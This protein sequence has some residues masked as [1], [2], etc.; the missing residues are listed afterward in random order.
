MPF[1]AEEAELLAATQSLCRWSAADGSDTASSEQ[2]V[3]ALPSTIDSLRLI[4]LFLRRDHPT[5]QPHHRSI[6][7]WQTAQTAL[8]PL[9]TTYKR[10]RQVVYPVM[11]LL[12][13]L[14][15][16][17]PGDSEA[18]CRRERLAHQKQIRTALLEGVYMDVLM[19]WLTPLLARPPATRSADD[20]NLIEL[21]LTLVKNLL[22]I[23]AGS[24]TQVNAAAEDAASSK[25]MEALQCMRGRPV[26]ERLIR[27]Y[28]ECG[29]LDML[30]ALCWQPEDLNK[31]GLLLLETVAHLVGGVSVSELL[32][33]QRKA[34]GEEEAKRQKQSAAASAQ[35]ARN[36]PAGQFSYLWRGQSQ[37]SNRSVSTS[38]PLPPPSA[39][40]TSSLGA[41]LHTARLNEKSRYV[42]PSRHSRF[43]TLLTLPSPLSASPDVSDISAPPVSSGTQ[44]VRNMFDMHAMGS[45]RL[46]SFRGR[47]P[48]Q[49][50]TAAA[51]ALST[52][53]E[54]PV[55]GELVEFVLQFISDGCYG[56]LMDSTIG[57]LKANVR[58]LRDDEKNW[59]AVAALMM[60]VWR[61]QQMHSIGRHEQL[62]SSN[63]QTE[64]QPSGDSSSSPTTT[65][66]T[67]FFNCE[68]VMSCLSAAA[69]SLLTSKLLLYIQ[70][71]PSP[72]SCLTAS[73]QLYSELVHTLSCMLRTASPADREA[74]N[75][76][77]HD[78]YY[79]K[80][81]LD[82]LVGL[83]R[84]W[85][86]HSWGGPLMALLVECVH[87]SMH[88]LD[89]VDGVHTISQRRKK[90]V[91]KNRTVLLDGAKQK[92]PIAELQQALPA[93][94]LLDTRSTS[95]PQQPEEQPGE[96]QH[97]QVEPAMAVVLPVSEHATVKAAVLQTREILFESEAQ[98]QA[99]VGS[100]V[101]SAEGVPEQDALVDHPAQD[102]TPQT[103]D[104]IAERSDA[105]HVATADSV[106]TQ[107]A[108]LPLPA[109]S[110]D[111]AADTVHL[112]DVDANEYVPVASDSVDTSAA[113]LELSAD[114]QEERTRLPVDTQ[115]QTLLL[116][117][118][119]AELDV[120]PP[121]HA[122]TTQPPPA[123]AM[124]DTDCANQPGVGAASATP[125]EQQTPT[126]HSF[127]PPSSVSDASLSTLISDMAIE[128]LDVVM[129]SIAPDD[130]GATEEQ[131]KA[132]TQPHI[133]QLE[134]TTSASSN[135]QASEE[136][137]TQ[138]RASLD[139]S[140]LTP[141]LAIEVPRDSDSAQ[142]SE[143]GYHRAAADV[144]A[145]GRVAIVAAVAVQH[146]ATMSPVTA[147]IASTPT[148]DQ[149]Q[150]AVSATPGDSAAV[151]EALEAAAAEEVE[152]SED[153]YFRMEATFNFSAYLLSYATPTI[154]SHYL[155]LLA[156][157]RTNS[158]SLNSHILHFLSRLAFDRQLLPMLFQLS[159][160][161]V[162]DA[163]LNDPLLKAEKSSPRWKELTS[164]CK[165][166]VRGFFDWVEREERGGMMFVECLFWKSVNA[167]ELMKGGYRGGSGGD[168]SE[169]EEEDR[170][171][172]HDE[173]AW[174]AELQA[175]GDGEWQPG[176][177]D[178]VS[179]A[180]AATAKKSKTSR[181][182]SKGGS[183]PAESAELD[184]DG[185]GE[186]I[187]LAQLMDQT[188]RKDKERARREKK[189]QRRKE[190]EAK[191]RERDRQRRA[192]MAV[193]DDEEEELQLGEYNEQ[194]MEERMRRERR[195]RDE[196]AEAEGVEK[197]WRAEE[198]EVLRKEYPLFAS[199]K[200]RYALMSS[201]LQG[202]FTLEEVKQKIAQL[203]LDSS[204]KA[205]DVAAEVDS[206]EASSTRSH[207]PL[208]V[209]TDLH[210]ATTDEEQSEVD[211]SD[212]PSDVS[213]PRA[214]SS[215]VKRAALPTSSRSASTP[216][217]SRAPNGPVVDV[218]RSTGALYDLVSD[219][220]R[221]EHHR[222]FLQQL[223]HSL[224]LC[225]QERQR[226]TAKHS[227]AVT[228]SP[229]RGLDENTTAGER[230]VK[231]QRQL[232]S[233]LKFV[234][235]R[236]GQW[237]VQRQYSAD[238]LE[239]VVSVLERAYGNTMDDL[240]AEGAQQVGEEESDREE[241]A[242][243][244]Q[245]EEAED[246]QD[247]EG[248]ADSEAASECDEA[249]VLVPTQRETRKRSAAQ[250]QLALGG[251]D[252]E[253]GSDA[254]VA[255]T[256]AEDEMDN[257]ELAQFMRQRRNKILAHAAPSAQQQQP[258]MD[259]AMSTGRGHKGRLRKVAEADEEE[260][261]EKEESNATTEQAAS[262]D[263]VP[264]VSAGPTGHEA[265]SKRRRVIVDDDD[266][267][268]AEMDVE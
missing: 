117:D 20:V 192:Q 237:S 210:T 116:V 29:V 68:P 51:A 240:S 177:H 141:T 4:E 17:L 204:A 256:R 94:V 185:T 266:D 189:E 134:Q 45:D 139:A 122:S 140:A 96:G 176:K 105:D 79:E 80:E 50:N 226:E 111:S 199:L 49:S 138:Q 73:L 123:D 150:T 198:E 158:L 40:S 142:H 191:E 76:L 220:A 1:D 162:C 129:D 173:Q 99:T 169:E 156:A 187:D 172:A 202:R 108:T 95:Q 243:A 135:R 75:R 212:M 34:E 42:A 106:D 254:A 23:A 262:H 120:P 227:A 91:L 71:K 110:I 147:T 253:S 236:G 225:A 160:L 265:S 175:Q 59:M 257:E 234:H 157:Y 31:F 132:R 70:E 208:G 103:D 22:A 39:S 19:Q 165:K 241:E 130:A 229:V 57:E 242:Q 53:G 255:V 33:E 32:A 119:E 18:E 245:Q 166:V 92:M 137:A 238:K 63:S 35:A 69:F 153:G 214:P 248:V 209:E 196:A 171:E 170:A 247:E 87:W 195:E 6:G 268:Q 82:L 181:K 126:P 58:V 44:L 104:A 62:T 114:E 125:V 174:Q 3:S 251:A 113:T 186:E 9:L 128:Q 154:V 258:Q 201:R 13:R 66:P 246:E 148:G 109:D 61:E 194:E 28:A 118:E 203:G 215:S 222:I 178:E 184:D 24:N 100:T 182:K 161:Q 48:R 56:R 219:M 11:K 47:T 155:T 136:L 86:A 5:Q 90:R 127:S 221:H 250:F 230:R 55:C 27:R 260:E 131:V 218:N 200:S 107:A 216:T 183:S 102:S 72:L 74:A 124:S 43:G 81:Q 224:T 10:D 89:D 264:V 207:A 77:R 193:E 149:A 97:G 252:A 38:Q 217:G 37:A 249:P 83:M 16:P 167:V 52:A 115:A 36:S 121:Q 85:N 93:N 144:A 101:D 235:T 211:P 15:M 64:P 231:R 67:P 233:A 60:G 25:Q 84:Q 164:F 159:C 133:D 180:E 261:K 78:F 206:A 213:S 2:S 112:P 41:Q 30:C 12:V 54:R 152:V 146:D 8:L 188:A 197:E 46:P 21:S 223:T 168:M 145:K 244:E 179:S 98:Q 228:L 163:I 267:E 26:G 232:L 259:G 190:V 7:R 88:M 14:T 143:V 65:S 151:G 263:V 205:K 239:A